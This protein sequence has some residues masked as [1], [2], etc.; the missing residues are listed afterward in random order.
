MRVLWL[1]ANGDLS[2]NS[3]L[4]KLIKYRCESVI[5]GL[6]SPKGGFVGCQLALRWPHGCACQRV[7]WYLS[8][9]L[10]KQKHAV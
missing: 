3:R 5:Q 2:R 7:G 4:K 6:I 1:G 10:Y 8:Y 9:T